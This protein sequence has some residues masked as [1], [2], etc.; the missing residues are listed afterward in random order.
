MSQSNRSLLFAVSILA[1]CGVSGGTGKPPI[2]TVVDLTDGGGD[3]T[4]GVAPAKGRAADLMQ[5]MCNDPE[6]D[7]GG[8]CTNTS[9]DASN[10]GECGN[11]C[12]QGQVCT[13]GQCKTQTMGGKTNCTDTIECFNMCEDQT[14][15]M[16][17]VA[18]ATPKAQMLQKALL[19]CVETACPSKNANDV[20]HE[21]NGDPN[22]CDACYNAAQIMNGKCFNQLQ[23]CAMDL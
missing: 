19:Q 21:I 12:A 13:T 11:A 14:C 2:K 10:C 1:A 7:C 16:T 9:S 4:D 20:C 8:V 5:H 23:A 15:S 17:C 3:L 18:N 6:R 22:Q